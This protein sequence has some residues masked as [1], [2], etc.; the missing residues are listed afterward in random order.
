[1]ANKRKEIMDNFDEIPIKEF[2]KM[3]KQG[4]NEDNA[5]YTAEDDGSNLDLIQKTEHPKW[6]V[7]MGAYKEIRDL[8]YNEYAKEINP[9]ND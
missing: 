1:M 6:K 2:H 5:D 3:D 7:R 8:F 4:A 9:L